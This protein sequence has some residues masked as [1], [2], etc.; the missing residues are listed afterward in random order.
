MDLHLR[1]SKWQTWYSAFVPM[2]RREFAQR[3][4]QSTQTEGANEPAVDST[5]HRKTVIVLIL[6]NGIARAATNGAVDGTAIVSFSPKCYLHVEFNRTTVISVISSVTVVTPFL[7]PHLRINA[8][9]RRSDD[10]EPSATHITVAVSVMIVAIVP[11]MAALFPMVPAVVPI[12]AAPFFPFLIVSIVVPEQKPVQFFMRQ[13]GSGGDRHRSA[14]SHR[15][16][17]SE[18]KLGTQH[19][20]NC[21]VDERGDGRPVCGKIQNKKRKAVFKGWKRV[22]VVCQINSRRQL[23]GGVQLI[24]L[25][26]NWIGKTSQIRRLR[27]GCFC[28]GAP[29]AP[30]TFASSCLAL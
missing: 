9:R 13:F 30:S 5:R 20:N 19:N 17:E 25:E 1:R 27:R 14:Q 11:G 22:V 3:Q 15:G 6:A 4:S 28:H 24:L 2:I 21:L 16:G 29:S 8:D 26:L 10:R 12:M 7:I 23:V 18:L